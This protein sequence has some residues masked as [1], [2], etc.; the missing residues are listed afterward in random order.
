ML[1]LLAPVCLAADTSPLDGLRALVYIL[2][3]FVSRPAGAQATAKAG[4][5]IRLYMNPLENT[6]Q[7]S[8]DGTHYIQPLKRKTTPE[9]GTDPV[10]R[11]CDHNSSLSSQ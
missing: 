4:D 7:L 8:A 9:S 10:G 11:G 5:V 1:V 6:V 2:S 3:R